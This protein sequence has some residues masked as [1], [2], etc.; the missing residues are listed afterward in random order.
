MIRSLTRRA[1]SNLRDDTEFVTSGKSESSALKNVSIGAL[2]ADQCDLVIV[3]L[4]GC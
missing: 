1:A 3:S 4:A 2:F